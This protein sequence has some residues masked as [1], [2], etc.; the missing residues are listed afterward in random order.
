MNVEI[1]KGKEE[2]EEKKLG[3]STRGQEYVE[4]FEQ[5]SNEHQLV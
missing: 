2:E 4:R 1:E 3:N 5:E